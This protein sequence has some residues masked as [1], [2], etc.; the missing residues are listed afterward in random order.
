MT[1]QG[2]QRQLATE[3]LSI[4]SAV[5]SQRGSKST[6]SPHLFGGR[7]GKHLCMLKDIKRGST[8]IAL[9]GRVAAERWPCNGRGRDQPIKK[10]TNSLCANP[11]QDS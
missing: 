7:F 9:G 1:Q 4:T 2:T 11:I 3:K 10:K 5:N 8:Q 6:A